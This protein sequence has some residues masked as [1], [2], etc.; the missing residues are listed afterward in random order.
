MI[1]TDVFLTSLISSA[2]RAPGRS[3]LFA[4]TRSVAPVR[5]CGE[6][7]ARQSNEILHSDLDTKGKSFHW[8][9]LVIIR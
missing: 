9:G 6:K 4:K 8:M 3:C 1:A 7:K 2:F 5:R